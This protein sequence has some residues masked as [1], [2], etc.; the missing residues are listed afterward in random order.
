[1]DLL[2]LVVGLI[3]TGVSIYAACFAV[4]EA[5]KAKESANKA[6]LMKKAI[7][8]EQN[9]ISISKIFTETK[10]SMLVSIKL[11]TSATPDKKIRG[12]D[13]QKSIDTIRQYVDTLKENYHYL[14]EEKVTLVENEYKKIELELVALAK[15]SDQ[16]IKYEIGDRIHSTMGEIMKIIKPELDIS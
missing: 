15:E 1:M 6:E 2:S 13:Y 7:E 3:G 4:K 8:R 12:L 5:K 14:P 16:T 9:K 10:S 11:A